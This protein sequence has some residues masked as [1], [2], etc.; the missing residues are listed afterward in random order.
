MEI[1]E[2]N[3][4]PDGYGDSY[5]KDESLWSPSLASDEIIK[6]YLTDCL[7]LQLCQSEPKD[8]IIYNKKN[9]PSK[10]IRKL[11]ETYSLNAFYDILL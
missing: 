3:D 10:F 6:E 5:E 11:L 7:I 4:R 9:D 8:I 1:E 2:Y